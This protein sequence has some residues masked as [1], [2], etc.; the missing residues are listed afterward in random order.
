[1]LPK[2]RIGNVQ[3]KGKS[4]LPTYTPM[5]W[6]GIFDTLIKDGYKGQVGLETHT[7]VETKIQMSHECRKDLVRMWAV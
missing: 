4:L 6:R 7:F 2:K 5:D 1:M 3:I